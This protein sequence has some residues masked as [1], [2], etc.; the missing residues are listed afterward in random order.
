MPILSVFVPV[1]NGSATIKDCIDSIL[2]Q[3]L[4][5]IEIIVVNDGSTDN[6]ADIVSSYTDSRIKLIT[7]ENSGQGIAR[8]KG[9]D[10][11]SGKYLGFVD[12]DDTIRANMYKSMVKVAEENQADMVQCAI[13][14]I[15]NDTVVKRPRM[16]E[17]YIEIADNASYTHN[18]FYSLV[19]TNEVCNKIYLKSLLAGNGIKFDNTFEVYSED[20]K[21]NIDILPYLRRVYFMEEAHYNYNITQS[22]HCLKNPEARLKGI[23][24]L[25][26]RCI[27]SIDDKK[28]RRCIKS[29]AVIN[30]LSYTLSA[31]TL[32][33][34]DELITSSFMKDCMWA[35][36]FYKKTLRHAFLMLALIIFPLDLKKKLIKKHYTF[37]K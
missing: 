6:T 26:K 10:I 27:A 15:R 28:I 1:Y 12:A 11:S 5:D 7:I 19:H 14:D 23:C 35:S 29:M 33:Y 25:Y 9:V 16:H 8:N 18:Y 17:T 3:S 22:G 31:D 34:V 30:L 37:D 36:C 20:M 4:R 21:L 24:T 32:P 13:N 2:A